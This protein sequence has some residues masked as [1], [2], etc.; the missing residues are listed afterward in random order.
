MDWNKII[1]GPMQHYNER[2]EVFAYEWNYLWDLIRAQGDNNANG[3]EMLMDGFISLDNLTFSP[4][5]ISVSEIPSFDVRGS[6]P[7]YIFDF[8]IPKGETGNGIYN[9]VLLSTSGLEKT[10]R[11]TFTNGEHS[12]YV[13]TDG[14]G[15]PEGG[16]SGDMLVRSGS[17][18]EWETKNALTNTEIEEILNSTV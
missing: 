17:S 18:A 1:L 11:I 9:I 13:V 4:G 12:D 7:D 6:F 16:S 10:Y 5:D 15:L 2:Q 3:I 14:E 8:G